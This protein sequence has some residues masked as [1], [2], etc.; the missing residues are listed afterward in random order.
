[1]SIQ[2]PLEAVKAALAANN[3]PGAIEAASQAVNE[4]AENALL[5]NVAAYGLQL[6]RRYDDAM[7]LLG[8]AFKLSPRDPQIVNA[9]GQVFSQQGRADQAAKA[10]EGAL[11]LDPRLAPAHNGLGLALE[12]LGDVD[13]AR[14]HFLLAAQYAPDFPDP[15]G[16]LAALALQRNATDEARDFARRALALDSFQPA[17]A[18]T[19]ATIDYQT[20][21]LD[22]A[23]TGI[24]ALLDRGQLA[25]LHESS[26]RKLLG[27]VL[28]ASQ[29][30]LEA[31][32]AYAQGNSLFRD[33][34]RAQTEGPGIEPGVDLTRRLAAYF[35]AAPD[36]AWTASATAPGPDAPARH[37]FMVGFYRSGT[38][39]LEQILASHPE[40]CTLEE[41]PILD[42]AAWEFFQKDEGL[43]RLADLDAETAERLGADYWRRVRSF[44]VE[45][46]GKVFV[47]KLPIGGLWAPFIAKVFPDALILFVR[48]DPRDVI[49][50]CFRH[51]FL[52]G[53]VLSEFTDINRTAM[54]YDG[55]MGLFEIYRR[56]LAI[57]VH[58]IRQEDLVRDFDHEVGA[59]CDFLG[60]SWREEMR[61]FADV[62]KTR[63][64]RTPSAPQVVLGLNASGI[65]RWRAYAPAMTEALAIVEPWVERFG[66]TPA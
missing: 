25:P 38:T 66:Y 47:D 50:S 65:G 1:L 26:A 58:V 27:D 30:P 63:D 51:R 33:V 16:S 5:F 52:P 4:G 20:G 22:P 55:M 60:I 37:V 6:Q 61:D 42:E 12:V 11:A 29:R 7:H 3:L 32:E 44:G 64:I 14:R 23:E 53:P 28:D 48:R 57:N 39:L 2:N 45:P 54:L 34:Y 62:A 40:V 21:A 17:A 10:F 9:I 18:I 56:R 36:G 31:F 35:A 59:I 19:L 43:D 49:L 15:L 13:R 8:R 24:R 41:R 46:G